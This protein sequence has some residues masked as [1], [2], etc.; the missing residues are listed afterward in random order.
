MNGPV[1]KPLPWESRAKPGWGWVV[2]VTTPWRGTGV[3]EECV[4]MR[5]CVHKMC[6]TFVSVR[7]PLCLCLRVTVRIGR[8]KA[9]FYGNKRG[10]GLVVVG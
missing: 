2:I 3:A 4:C 9:R 5:V 1:D 6:N 7:V 10:W 8:I